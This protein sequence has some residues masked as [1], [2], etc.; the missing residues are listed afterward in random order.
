MSVEQRIKISC[1]VFECEAAIHSGRSLLDARAIAGE[2]GWSFTMHYIGSTMKQVLQDFCPEH[3]DTAFDWATWQAKELARPP[4]PCICDGGALR[5]ES[6]NRERHPFIVNPDCL[7]HGSK[8]R[9]SGNGG[10]KNG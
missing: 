2:A 9:D 4:V 7:M 1:D 3:R 8:S 6:E 5:T 10:T